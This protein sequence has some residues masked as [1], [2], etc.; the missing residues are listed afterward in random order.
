MEEDLM[1]KKIVIENKNSR[2]ERDYL[3]FRV[4]IP[5][6][7]RELINKYISYAKLHFENQ[8]W[9][10]ME[11]GM[12]HLMESEKLL[13]IYVMN[14]LEEL[15]EKVNEL[16]DKKDNKEKVVTFTGERK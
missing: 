11:A 10:V 7:N 13:K 5:P 1:K 9:K 16:S 12:D 2:Q 8:V 4:Y 6:E 14:K 3:V 15:E